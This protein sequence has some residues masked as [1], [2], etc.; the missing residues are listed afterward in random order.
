MRRYRLTVRGEELV[1]NQDIRLF[2]PNHPA[3]VD[4]PLLGAYLQ[5]RMKIV[6]I[7]SDRF[8]TMPV[9][10]YFM[11]KMDSIS[12]TDLSTGKRDPDVL[13]NIMIQSN[14]SVKEGKNLILYPAGQ[15]KERAA[16]EIGNKQSA[17]LLVSELP[18]DVRIIGVKITGL[19][20]S[21]WS[22][23]NRKDKPNFGLTLLKGM[24]LTFANLIFLQPKRKVEIEFQDISDQARKVAQGSRQEFNRYLEDFYNGPEAEP[25]VKVRYFF[26]L[27]I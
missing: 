6:P 19:W 27:P 22:R 10:G 8:V 17:Y 25:N 9:V 24:L 18:E 13:K 5:K 14:E 1:N 16:E 2:L 11:R 21:M 12:V 26:Y 4:A 7:V 15:I 23:A 20:G 3:Q